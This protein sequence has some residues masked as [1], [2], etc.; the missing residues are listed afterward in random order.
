MPVCD[1]I[2]GVPYTLKCSVK[3]G[4]D[5]RYGGISGDA[6]VGAVGRLSGEQTEQSGGGFI[7][8]KGG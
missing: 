4:S 3:Q 1:P 6:G 8:P 7:D 2:Q 5:I